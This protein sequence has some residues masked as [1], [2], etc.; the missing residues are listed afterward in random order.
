MVFNSEMW[1]ELDELTDGYQ[2]GDA[3]RYKDD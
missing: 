3:G 2:R 1:T